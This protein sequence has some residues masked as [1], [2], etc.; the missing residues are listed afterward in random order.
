MENIIEFLKKHKTK[1]LVI[2]VVFLFFKSC[3][4]SRDVKVLE[5]KYETELENINKQNEIDKSKSYKQGQIDAL[6]TVIDDV[7]KI[8]RPPVLMDLHNKW[9]NDRDK[10]SKGVK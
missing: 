6:N 2:L 7:S 4:G 10:I 9:I 3:G 5:K 1:L 8:N